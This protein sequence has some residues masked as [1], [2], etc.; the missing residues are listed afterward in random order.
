[1]NWRFGGTFCLNLQGSNSLWFLARTTSQKT[2]FCIVTAVKTS[3]LTQQIP[4][5]EICI[6]VKHIFPVLSVFFYEINIF[7]LPAGME[8]KKGNE[9]FD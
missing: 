9:H 7:T 5:F 4:R 1:V 2:T 6:P 8:K 3:N